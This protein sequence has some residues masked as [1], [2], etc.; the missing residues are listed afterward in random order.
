M[1]PP[2]PI[3]TFRGIGEPRR[4]GQGELSTKYWLNV[5]LLASLVL[6]T[7]GC[8]TYHGVRAI[9]PMVRYPGS[10]YTVSSLQP[11]LEWAPSEAKDTTYDVIVV[12]QL[13]DAQNH[14]LFNPGRTVF[15][16][17]GITETKVKIEPPLVLDTLYW[18]TVRSRN[19]GKV[20]EWSRYDF[21]ASYGYVHM[22]SKNYPYPF[23]TPVNENGL[24]DEPTPR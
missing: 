11:V 20:S 16:R 3:H 24:E 7:Y 4:I 1:C 5:V 10:P 18:W 12:E 8:A 15:Y 17:E 14:K 13:N 2:N 23:R 19:G 9:S 6:N 22:T 21:T